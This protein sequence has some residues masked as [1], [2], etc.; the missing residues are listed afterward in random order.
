MCGKDVGTGVL[1]TAAL[2]RPRFSAIVEKPEGVSK[3]PPGP[4]RVKA[5]SFIFRRWRKIGAIR[6]WCLIAHITYFSLSITSGH[7]TQ[8]HT[9]FQIVVSS[10]LIEKITNSFVRL[11]A[12]FGYL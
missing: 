2:Q 9:Q 6:V 10:L 3:H 5:A 4:A 1:K 7:L 11:P 8:S 12:S